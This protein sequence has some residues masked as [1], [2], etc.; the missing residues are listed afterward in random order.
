MLV[1]TIAASFIT[2]RLVELP[3]NRWFRNLASNV[4]SGKHQAIHSAA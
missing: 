2:C 1:L 4:A 3:A